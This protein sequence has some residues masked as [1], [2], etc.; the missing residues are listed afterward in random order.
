[1][2]EWLLSCRSHGITR[3][4]L[5]IACVRG[6]R[7]I[8]AGFSIGRERYYNATVEGELLGAKFHFEAVSRRRLHGDEEDSVTPLFIGSFNLAEGVSGDFT[9]RPKL[10]GELM[11]LGV[12]GAP[13][14]FHLVKTAPTHTASPIELRGIPNWTVRFE[15]PNEYQPSIA[16]SALRLAGKTRDYSGYCSGSGALADDA[17]PMPGVLIAALLAYQLLLRPFYLTS[18]D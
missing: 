15:D 16:K 14:A 4:R 11:A 13:P 12:Y 10:D 1:M 8:E 3:P 7:R 6:S 9:V 18:S 5:E 17:L 2:R